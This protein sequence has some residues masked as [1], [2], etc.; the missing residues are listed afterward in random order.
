MS[1]K[2][3][4]NTPDPAADVSADAGT[5]YEPTK[6]AEEVETDKANAQARTDAL[7]KAYGLATKRLRQAHLDEFNRYRVEESAK[8]DYEWTP[9][10]SAEA[11][12]A[13]QLDELLAA[14]PALRDKM[15]AAG[16]VAPEPTE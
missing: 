4:R 11:K 16:E 10:A 2:T 9:P 7:T 5:E 8:L 1:S 12:A 6:T 13:K 14:H 3:S 15:V